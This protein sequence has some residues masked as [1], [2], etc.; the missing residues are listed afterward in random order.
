M[1]NITVVNRETG[2]EQIWEAKNVKSFCKPEDIESMRKE[3][4]HKLMYFMVV[5]TGLDYDMGMWEV[6]KYDLIVK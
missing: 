2:E 6:D 1:M 4:D 3:K 5:F